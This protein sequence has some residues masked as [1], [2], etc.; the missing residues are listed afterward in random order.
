MIG[1]AMASASAMRFLCMETLRKSDEHSRAGWHGGA[2][3]TATELTSSDGG[4]AARGEW[5]G[6]VRRNGSGHKR[7]GWL[8]RSFVGK[9]DYL[10]GRSAG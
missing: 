1:K 4:R 5:R 7:R 3:R 2:R 9:R 10:D 6:R 8:G